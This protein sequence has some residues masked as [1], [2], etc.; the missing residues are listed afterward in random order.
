MFIKDYRNV[1][2]DLN[3]RL[4]LSS[5]LFFS[6]DDLDKLIQ[7]NYIKLIIK[8]FDTKLLIEAMSYLK[9]FDHK[10]PVTIYVGLEDDNLV[11]YNL[12]KADNPTSEFSLGWI[13]ND[14][15]LN[16]CDIHGISRLY[17]NSEAIKFTKIEKTEH[18]KVLTKYKT[19]MQETII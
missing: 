1:I 9:P 12:T 16:Q 5:L 13:T 19:K 7:I 8:G 11:K 10:I 15:T 17:L 18:D 4:F 14:V 6:N 3:H 2:F